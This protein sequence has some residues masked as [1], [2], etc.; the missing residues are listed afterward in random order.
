MIQATNHFSNYYDVLDTATIQQ[1]DDKR[2]AV[3]RSIQF[4]L[5]S[6]GKPFVRMQIEDTNGYL[7]TGR[8]FDYIDIPS[9]GTTLTKLTGKLVLISYTVD[10]Y[11]GS[12]CLLIK[13][14][15]AIKEEYADQYT[16]YF[17]GKYTLASIRLS[18]CIKLIYAMTLSPELLDFYNTY[19]NIEGLV[20]LSDES[21]SKGLRG[22]ILEILKKVLL[23]SSD[24]SGDA[25]IAFLTAIICKFYTKQT[26]EV[27]I[28][29][30]K[31]LFIASM[32]DRKLKAASTGLVGLSN[33]I[34]EMAALFSGSSHVISSETMFL[35]NLYNTLTEA[36]NIAVLEKQLP[37]GGFC[38]YNKYTIRRS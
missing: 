33:K 24:I 38:T 1:G 22:Y 16:S 36:S 18:E 28:D 13:S 7:I 32:M 11:N 35:F 19:C 2:L 17:T 8:M 23:L 12:A 4:R 9:V 26:A 30:N 10:Y 6:E 37:P 27:S 3:L 15:E 21:V 25:V 29:D 34:S 14:I 5:T 31:M 20:T